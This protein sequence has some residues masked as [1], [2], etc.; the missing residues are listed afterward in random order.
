MRPRHLLFGDDLGPA[1]VVHVREPSLGL[2]AVLVIDN[3]ARH[4]MGD[5]THGGSGGVVLW[6]RPPGR[7]RR[8]PGLRRRRQAQRPLS[9]RVRRGADRRLQFPEHDPQ[10]GR[11]RLDSRRPS[12]L[13]TRGQRGAL[14]DAARP[15][16]SEHSLHGGRGGGAARSRRPPSRRR[17]A[18]TPAPSSTPS[19]RSASRPGERRST[20]RPR[21][22]GGR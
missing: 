4:R 11:H 16:G 8:D 22:C 10:R 21:R 17:F 18:R 3:V 12:R 14:E 6:S 7:A 9:R 19:G 13:R 1:K 20:S 2:E 15:A 5:P